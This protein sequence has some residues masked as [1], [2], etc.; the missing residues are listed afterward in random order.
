MQTHEYFPGGNTPQGFYSYYKHILPQDTAEKIIVLKGGPGTGKSS[1]MRKVAALLN[2]NGYAT[3]LLHC[4]SDPDSLDAIVSR[5]LGFCMLDGTAPHIVDPVHP[6]AVDTILHLGA[7]WDEGGIQKHKTDIM[8]LSKSISESFAN[9]YDYLKAAGSVQNYIRK[10]T[11]KH[12][13]KDGIT[14][15][16]YSLIAN[17]KLTTDGL[18]RGKIKK[19]FISALTPK[20]NI[21]YIDSFAASAKRVIVIEAT[22][23]VSALFT[24]RLAAR[25]EESGKDAYFFYCPMQPDTKIEHIYLP[26]E[27]L[28]ITTANAFH[29]CNAAAEHINLNAYA[30]AVPALRA[31]TDIF[32]ILLSRAIA[33][34]RNAKTL[35]DELEQYY[36]PHMDFAA[37]A[38]LPNKIVSKLL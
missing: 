20:G 16:L 32:N 37:M 8:H 30:Q 9:A 12:T 14:K 33:C 19:A 6:G 38:D 15:Q 28:L 17:L 11:L 36:V 25:I 31:D 29:S 22:F 2:E 26:Q 13:D 18:K 34:L 1:L 10:A 21:G 24:N 23:D 5:T 4:S 27:A 7:Y 3:D 35:H